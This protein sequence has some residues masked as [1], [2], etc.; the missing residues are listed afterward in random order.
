MGR[1]LGDAGLAKG[2]LRAVLL[3]VAL[4]AGRAAGA[5]LG[6]QTLVSRGGR[7]AS[8]RLSANGRPSCLP[9]DQAFLAATA[10]FCLAPLALI[11]PLLEGLGND[12]KALLIKAAMDGMA[13]VT[14]VRALGVAAAGA[15]LPVLAIQGSIGLWTRWMAMSHAHP[16][17]LAGLTAA[18]GFI[19]LTV[20]L[21]VFGINRIRMADYLPALLLAPLLFRLAG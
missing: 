2:L 13:M 3:L 4:I 9:G 6:V 14:L 21:V 12:F 20:A 1:G 10:V 7:Y 19:V 5:A 16:A 15:A 17:V 18:S 8:H 11:G